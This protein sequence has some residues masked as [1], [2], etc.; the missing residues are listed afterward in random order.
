VAKYHVAIDEQMLI[1]AIKTGQMDFIYCVWAYNKNY[2]FTYDE[3]EEQIQNSARDSHDG[4]PGDPLKNYRTFTFDYLIKKILAFC[5]DEAQTH[6][7]SVA[8]WNLE[9]SENLLHS[10]LINRQDKIAAEYGKNYL[11]DADEGLLRDAIKDSN[12]YFLKHAF[13]TQIFPMSMLIKPDI[14]VFLL[15]CLKQGLKTEMILNILIF[16]DFGRWT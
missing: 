16:T 6:L 8:K 7:A 5:E 1:R 10:L 12:E 14:I 4:N 9:F 2:E 11:K 3:E 15:T 13:R